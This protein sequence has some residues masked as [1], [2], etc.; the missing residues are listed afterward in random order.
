MPFTV[1]GERLPSSDV[2]RANVPVPPHR[3]IAPDLLRISSSE[4]TEP[5]I[6]SMPHSTAVGPVYV[7]APER[8]SSPPPVFRRP[9]SF[10]DRAGSCSRFCAIVYAPSPAFAVEITAPF[11]ETYAAVRPVSVRFAAA[12]P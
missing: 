4:A 12:A 9:P 1:C 3:S 11:V 2:T 5:V 10:P 6:C 8:V 7:F